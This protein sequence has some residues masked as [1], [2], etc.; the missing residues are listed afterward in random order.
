M[1]RGNGREKV[2]RGSCDTAGRGGRAR[3][4][5][6]GEGEGEGS[7]NGGRGGSEKRSGDGRS[8]RDDEEAVGSIGSTR[9]VRGGGARGGS[10]A[11][12]GVG[13]EAKK[14]WARQRVGG[15]REATARRAREAREILR[16]SEQTAPGG[17]DCGDR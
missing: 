12:D 13:G 4:G 9:A 17:G 16:Q 3:G 14:G 2:R 15:D 5:G 6:R 7:E 10:G 1:L 8:S 11:G